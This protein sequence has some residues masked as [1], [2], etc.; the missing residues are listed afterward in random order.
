MKLSKEEI[1]NKYKNIYKNASIYILNYMNGDNIVVSYGLISEINE[2]NGINHK[3]NTDN[4]SSG[5]PILSLKNNKLIGIHYDSPNK[6]EY[7]LGTLIIYAIIDFNKIQNNEIKNEIQNE[8]LINGNEIAI[9]YK[10][11]NNDKKIK[12]FGKPFIEKNKNNCKIIIDNKEKEIIEYIDINEEMKK[13]DKL[14][15]KLKEIKAITNLSYMFGDDWFKGCDKLISLPDISNWDTKNVTNM[16]G[17]FCMCN[18]LSSLPDIS[19]WDTKNVTKMIGMFYNCYKLSSLPDISKWNTKNVT[20]MCLMF[21]NCKSLSSLPDISNWDT[22]NVTNTSY[23]FSNCYKLSSL[24]DISKW[25]TK[26]V[27]DM[28]GMF[29]NCY[30]LSKSD[31]PLKFK[32]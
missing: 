15:I 9:I 7:N 25:D 12:L 28:S 19:N 13:K 14:E 17:M 30:K 11:D 20:N 10:I 4:G 32:K 29:N 5:S 24:P 8:N 3:C 21:S 6:Y 31:I 27:T 16:S 26:N 2:D 22:K 18:L 23:M 1:I